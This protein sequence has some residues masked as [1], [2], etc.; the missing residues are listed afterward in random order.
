MRHRELLKLLIIFK[1]ANEG[2]FVRLYSKDCVLPVDV[3]Y[4]L[5][6]LYIAR[7]GIVRTVKQGLC[8]VL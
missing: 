2:C 6:L 4:V 5:R 3:P 1:A 8:V 7:V